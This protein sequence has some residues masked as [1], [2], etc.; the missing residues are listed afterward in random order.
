[1]DA[2]SPANEASA[3]EDAMGLVLA[4][5]FRSMDDGC[6]EEWVTAC[7]SE[8]LQFV[9]AGKQ[10]DPSEDRIGFGR[11]DFMT[12]YN[13]TL[14][15]VFHAKSRGIAWDINQEVKPLS[16]ETWQVDWQMKIEREDGVTPRA[17]RFIV[18][19]RDLA[20]YHLLICMKD[21]SAD[22]DENLLKMREFV[23]PQDK[24]PVPPCLHNSWDS[25]RAKNSHT[26]LRCR[27]CEA[28]WKMHASQ[29]HMFRCHEFIA[30]L[31]PLPPASCRRIH[32]HPRKHRAAER[33]EPGL[34]PLPVKT[35]VTRADGG[36]GAAQ[37]ARHRRHK[38]GGG[39]G[40]VVKE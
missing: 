18:S 39:R 14:A 11:R 16:G 19:V 5:L 9:V 15:N 32:V 20:V 17:Y 29:N 22:M 13:S 6:F 37:P 34:A 36:S 26:M 28:L 25:V 31:C 21:R 2:E 33:Q 8:D 24:I 12:W 23:P 1:M 7:T 35:T 4:E 40:G 3:A 10:D 30:G 38:R 27:D